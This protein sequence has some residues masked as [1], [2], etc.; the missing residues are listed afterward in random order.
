MWL[1]SAGPESC[2]SITL[3]K[4]HVRL[5]KSKLIYEDDGKKCTLL[6]HLRGGRVIVNITVFAMWTFVT[7][8]AKRGNI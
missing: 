7:L 8:K 1:F 6:P 2:V 5:A 3:S 4:N